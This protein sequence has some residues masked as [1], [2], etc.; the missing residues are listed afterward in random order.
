VID[1]LV[2]P[3]PDDDPKGR[4]TLNGVNVTTWDAPATNK[5]EIC[6]IAKAHETVSRRIPDTRSDN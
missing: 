6:A 3:A 5:C 2:R 4:K 1:D